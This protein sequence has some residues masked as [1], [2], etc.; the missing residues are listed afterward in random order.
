MNA[1]HK[2]QLSLLGVDEDTDYNDYRT[3]TK[4]IKN[5][6]SRS[7]IIAISIFLTVI[8]VGY[9]AKP[10]TGFL[11]GLLLWGPFLFVFN[12][13]F[14]SLMKAKGLDCKNCSKSL[15]ISLSQGKT[16]YQCKQCGTKP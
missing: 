8:V 7:L 16:Y 4:A 5:I 6:K 9:F 12:A 3:V 14:Y 10:G 2:A 13:C 1:Y 11:V 15:I